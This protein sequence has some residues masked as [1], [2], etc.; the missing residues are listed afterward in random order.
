MPRREIRELAFH[1][2]AVGV[3]QFD[4]DLGLH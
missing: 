3:P 1:D 4:W 2:S